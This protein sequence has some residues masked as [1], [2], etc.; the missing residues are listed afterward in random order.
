MNIL[1]KP[2]CPG[3]YS[4][5]T[6]VPVYQSVRR[7]IPHDRNLNTSHRKNRKPRTDTGIYWGLVV[8]C[9]QAVPI[10]RRKLQLPSSGWTWG[11][12]QEQITLRPTLNPG[13]EPWSFSPHFWPLQSERKTVQAVTSL[14]FLHSE[15]IRF[16]SRQEHRL[17][18]TRFTV[19]FLSPSR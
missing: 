7:H 12:V 17:S 5:E 18:W 1:K 4:L 13:Q 8:S 14:F 15:S 19:T 10:F 11:R 6:W 16:E 3:Q 9:V 2:P